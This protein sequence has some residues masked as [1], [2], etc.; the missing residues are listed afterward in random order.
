MPAEAHPIYYDNFEA[1]A[2][3]TKLLLMWAHHDRHLR[4]MAPEVAQIEITAVPYQCQRCLPFA[5]AQIQFIIKT[6]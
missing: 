6:I 2:L 3:V 4:N 1:R 5:G